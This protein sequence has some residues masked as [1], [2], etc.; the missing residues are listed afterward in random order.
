MD[1][2]ADA[3]LLLEVSD[4]ED[5]GVIDIDPT[6]ASTLASA[7][8]LMR[9]LSDQRPWSLTE[10]GARWLGEFATGAHR[11]A[12]RLAIFLDGYRRSRMAAFS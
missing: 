9:S 12:H 4:N 5:G 7:G 2:L 6:R 3:V 8:L 10:A 1:Q 11:D